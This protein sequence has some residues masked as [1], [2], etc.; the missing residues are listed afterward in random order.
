MLERGS[1]SDLLFERH[2]NNV[3]AS[4]KTSDTPW[5][6]PRFW[7]VMA[8][9]LLVILALTMLKD[10]YLS[11]Q[12]PNPVFY[13]TVPLVSILGAT[14]GGYGSAR[15]L[16]QGVGLNDV[17]AIALITAILGQVFENASKLIWYRV[18]EYPGWL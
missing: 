15:L 10:L 5:R 17:L 3:V 12:Q 6:L 11:G 2:V 18:W 14:L 9:L 7:W 4:P 1:G 16:R 8:G 13:L